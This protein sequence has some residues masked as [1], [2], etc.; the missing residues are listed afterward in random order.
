MLLEST[1]RNETRIITLYTVK[2]NVF[3][4]FYFKSFIRWMQEE[5]IEHVRENMWYPVYGPLVHE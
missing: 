4:P 1:K 5:T 2:K 3:P